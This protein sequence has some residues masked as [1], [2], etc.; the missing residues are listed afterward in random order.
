MQPTDAQDLLAV[1]LASSNGGGLPSV[2]AL[3]ADRF[4]ANGYIVLLE[5]WLLH[6]L[7]RMIAYT[8]EN[9]LGL[10]VDSV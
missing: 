1:D 2:T 7:N 10:T 5:N 3:F 9:I 4:L 6:M 8:L